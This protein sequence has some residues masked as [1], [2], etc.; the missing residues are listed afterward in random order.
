M[1]PRASL[2]RAVSASLA[3]VVF[4]AGGHHAAKNMSVDSNLSPAAAITTNS[5]RFNDSSAP[6]TLT[7]TG[8]NVISSGGIMV[9]A[10]VG[11]NASTITG[12]N[13]LLEI[14]RSDAVANNT[15]NLFNQTGGTAN[16]GIL[17][18][19]GAVNGSTGV[20]STMT[21]TG[22][23]FSANVF[24]LLAAGNTNTAVIHIGGTADVTL[25]AFPTTRGTGSSAIVNFDGGT[26]RP[27]AASGTYMG[28]L[29]AANIKAGGARF[30][31]DSGKDITVTQAL[32]ADVSSPGGGLTKDGAGKLTLAGAS[33]YTGATV[34]SS[35]TRPFSEHSVPSP[36]CAAAAHIETNSDNLHI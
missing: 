12:G 4:T 35:G 7:L 11:N 21:L 22:G 15:T 14:G 8:A 9:T 13:A 20:N 33:T 32:L 5:L 31:V 27:L 24:S 1:K 17:A 18:I 16:V 23:T 34:I 36:C 19:G 10:N 2:F 28:G 26:L 6:R 25:P 29:T 30:A 3:A